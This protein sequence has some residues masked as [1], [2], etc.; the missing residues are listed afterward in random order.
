MHKG[1]IEWQRENGAQLLVTRGKHGVSFLHDREFHT[2][3]API[4]KVVDTTGAGDAFNAAFSYSYAGGQQLKDAIAFAV[5]AASL[6]VTKFG[7]QEGMPT[8]KEI[9]MAYGNAG[10]F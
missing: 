10:N 5:K 4:V 6:S 8:M 2:V 9:H 1:M 7:A 3:A